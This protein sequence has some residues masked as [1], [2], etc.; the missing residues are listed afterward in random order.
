[1]NKTVW[2]I[3]AAVIIIGAGWYVFMGSGA[4]VP[5]GMMGPE[6]N[7]AQ[8][9]QM[10][11]GTPMSLA[12]LMAGGAAQKCT[13]DD[14]MAGS[15]TSGTVYVGGGKVRT[16]FTSTQDG[17]TMSGHM[18]TDGTTM[19]TWIDGMSRGF[20]MSNI[21]SQ[22]AEVPE[23]SFDVNKKVDYRCEAWTVDA[24][25]FALPEGVTFQDMAEIMKG[26]QMPPVR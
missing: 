4:D 18:V 9:Q 15:P 12:E 21:A 6:G 8:Q 25:V 1:M 16:D 19:H 17:K 23:Q 2:G 7:A 26:I 5:A 11:G 13:F 22:G 20:K 14:T 24:S 3:V 10:T